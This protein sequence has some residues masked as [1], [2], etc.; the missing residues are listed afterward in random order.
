MSD[1]TIEVMHS[2]YSTTPVTSTIAGFDAV[3]IS[4]VN[5]HVIDGDL[6]GLI[7][8][9]PAGG[10]HVI[11]GS[12]ANVNSTSLTQYTVSL[13]RAPAAGETVTVTPSSSDPRLSFS[14][15]LIFNAGNWNTPQTV[16]ISA[17]DDGLV[18]GETNQT[19][20]ATVTSSMA[21]GGVYSAGV[22]D[23]PTLNVD[24]LDSDVG[25]VLVVPARR[26]DPG[27][28]DQDRHLH[29]AAEPGPDGPGDDHAAGRRP[30]AAV[31]GRLALQRHR[32]RRVAPRRWCSTAPTGTSR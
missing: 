9:T 18:Q 8:S 12:D 16:T 25:E 20:T 22:N 1:A 27:R 28:V 15:P 14:G 3:P 5:V 10:L 13:T 31:L 23:N 29:P 11:E 19:I 2:I 4:D 17:A 30:D 7:T 24:V 21:T 32:R 26:P 6:P